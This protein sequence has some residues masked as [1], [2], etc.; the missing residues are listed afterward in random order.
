MQ[1]CNKTQQT[2]FA[3]A[4]SADL[5]HKVGQIT[6]TTCTIVS[7]VKAEDNYGYFYLEVILEGSF[8]SKKLSQSH[9]SNID[10]YRLNHT[11]HSLYL[12]HLVAA[13]QCMSVRSCCK[14]YSRRQHTSL[15]GPFK[16]DCFCKRNMHLHPY[17]T[18]GDT[19]HPN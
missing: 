1:S 12:S 18:S 13:S 8:T 16:K 4:S 15:F 6:L 10:A 9:R 19:P 7:Q 11:F 5:L 17:F 2:D 14:I 3:S